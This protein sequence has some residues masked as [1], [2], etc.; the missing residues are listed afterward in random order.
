MTNM[1][2]ISRRSTYRSGTRFNH[3]GA[4]HEGNVANF[5]ETENII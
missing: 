4:D 1:Y 5:V 2:L 3:R